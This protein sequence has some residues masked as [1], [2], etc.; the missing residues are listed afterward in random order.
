MVCFGRA[1]EVGTSG[2]ATHV[3]MG[4]DQGAI[5]VT[6]SVVSWLRFASL[7]EAGGPAADTIGSRLLSGQ[8]HLLWVLT[9]PA[10]AEVNPKSTADGKSVRLSRTCCAG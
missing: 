1:E 3:L 10:T 8:L 4:D 7:V 5:T 6:T 2:R 9:T